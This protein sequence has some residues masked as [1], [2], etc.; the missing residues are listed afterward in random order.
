MRCVRNN[1]D[2]RATIK[3]GEINEKGGVEKGLRP[4]NFTTHK[5]KPMAANSHFL[6]TRT[7]M[8]QDCPLL[9]GKSNGFGHVQCQITNYGNDAVSENIRSGQGS[10]ADDQN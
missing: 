5:A 2:T 9:F 10:M 4:I 8:E 3:Q 1:T 6:Q 7:G